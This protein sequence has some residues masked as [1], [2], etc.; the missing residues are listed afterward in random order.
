MNTAQ[1][2]QVHDLEFTIQITSQPPER[3]RLT[4]FEWHESL[5]ECYLGTATIASR[6]FNINPSHH[7]DQTVT[8][9]IKHK[10]DPEIRYLHGII[11]SMTARADGPTTRFVYAPSFIALHLP[12]MHVFFNKRPC[13]IL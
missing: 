9:Q 12:L 5:S 4:Q 10:Y 11:Q 6:D 3:F 8:L 1:R 13:P 2:G 7:I